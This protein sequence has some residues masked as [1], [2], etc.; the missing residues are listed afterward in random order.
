M[1]NKTIGYVLL[2]AGAVVGALSYP[3]IRTAL[4]ISIPTTVADFYILA[5][6]AALLIVGAIISFKGSGKQPAEVPIYHG[7]HIVGYR[8]MK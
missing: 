8:R 2:A 3:E 1:A 5:I 7:K 4:K 6:G